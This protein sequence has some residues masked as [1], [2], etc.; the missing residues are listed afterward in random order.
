RERRA[1]VRP[2]GARVVVRGY[3][4]AAGTFVAGKRARA[5]QRNRAGRAAVRRPGRRTP[6]P[7][8]VAA[9]A[10][11]A[12]ESRAVGARADRARPVGE[13]VEPGPRGPGP[14]HLATN[15]GAETRPPRVPPA[16]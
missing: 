16:P 7:T 5:P 3:R 8:A 9:S 13:R 1:P 2:T 15:V 10:F 14:R 6:P 4:D 11:I 12:A